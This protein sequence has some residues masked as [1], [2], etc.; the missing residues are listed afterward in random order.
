MGRKDKLQFLA[1]KQSFSEFVKGQ[2]VDP[3]IHKMNVIEGS[4]NRKRVLSGSIVTNGHELQVLAYSLTQAAQSPS[5]KKRPNTTRSKLTDVKNLF[6]QKDLED[7]F[8][9]TDKLTVVGIDPGLKSTATYCVLTNGPDP[10]KNITISSGAHAHIGNEYRKG[11]EKAK[12]KAG[13][14]ELEGCITPIQC[15]QAEPY[16]QSESWNALR[17]S[18]EAHV[19][20]V[21]EVQ[22]V[23]RE[24][25][26][27][28]MF[29]VKTYH[30]KQAIQ[31]VSS[32]SIDRAIV[33]AGCTGKPQ[34]GASRPL[35]V[36]GDGEFGAKG[37]VVLH[38]N[39][40]SQRAGALGLDVVCADE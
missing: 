29:K 21:L 28:S 22:S 6:A 16:Q 38:Q 11:L 18:V 9:D 3:K 7:V 17:L 10:P 33:A 31:S 27:S 8:G 25:Y 30:R 23:L 36:V 15:P 1:A 14:H 5:A 24:F 13:I 12:E 19:Q 37:G 2:L 20:S 39:F 4:E 26:T 40:I 32:K 34:E 35:F